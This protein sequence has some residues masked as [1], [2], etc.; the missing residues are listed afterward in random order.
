MLDAIKSLYNDVNCAV[1][2]NDMFSTWFKVSTG[3]KQGCKM[4]TSLFSVYNNDLVK[5]I[6]D[7]N[8]GITIDQSMISLLIY[9]DDIV[10][11]APSAEDLQ[12]ML[13]TVNAWCNKWRLIV[14]KDK[15]RIVHFR[16]ASVERCNIV[17]K[18]GEN[19]IEYEKSYKYLGIWLNEHL[20]MK[21]TVSEITKSASRALSAMY[22]KCL[23]SGGMTLEVYKKLYESMVE[24]VL[25]YGAGIWGI[26][27]HK[28]IQTVQNKACRYFLGGGKYAANVALRGDMGWHSTEVKVKTE[29]F[30]FNTKLKR[31]P[32]E[33]LI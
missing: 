20:N 23:R 12:L 3:L 14:N 13:N 10:L 29:V 15:T 21:K 5:E 32:N 11:L 17:F 2:V 28:Q 1:K 4:S 8:C 27:Q 22:T 16:T 7:L 9:A 24:P 6:N 18:C 33:R 26:A 19:E 31:L 25:L 30:R